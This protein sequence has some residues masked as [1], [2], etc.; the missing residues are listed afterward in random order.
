LY[1]NWEGEG[2]ID[3]PARSL[4]CNLV[5]SGWENKLTLS[6][7]RALT[8]KRKKRGDIPEEGTEQE[9]LKPRA[10]GRGWHLTIGFLQ[11]RNRMTGICW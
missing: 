1:R 6:G 5:A 9:V 2:K 7:K 11:S 4:G 10:R 8:R 3:E